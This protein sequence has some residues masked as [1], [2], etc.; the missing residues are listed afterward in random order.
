MPKCTISKSSRASIKLTKSRINSSSV[1][2]TAYTV[3]PSAR[4]TFINY[5]GIQKPPL[6][7]S[8]ISVTLNIPLLLNLLTDSLVTLL[9]NFFQN[10]F[11]MVSWFNSYTSISQDNN[12]LYI[13]KHYNIHN[14][15]IPKVH[16]NQNGYIEGQSSTYITM[17]TLLRDLDA[18][19]NT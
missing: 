8:K 19:R 12:F 11:L 16:N 2:A 10:I 3:S 4:N 6:A 14:I 15:Q 9:F 18:N 1:L 17:K 13:W 5:I 7:T